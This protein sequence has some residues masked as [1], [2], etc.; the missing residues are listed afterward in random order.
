MGSKE[1]PARLCNLCVGEGRQGQLHPKPGGSPTRRGAGLGRE[2]STDRRK[3]KAAAA[4]GAGEG[5]GAAGRRGQVCRQVEGARSSLAWSRCGQAKVLLVGM[6]QRGQGPLTFPDLVTPHPTSQG[7]PWPFPFALAGLGVSGGSPLESSCLRLRSLSPPAPHPFL[8]LSLC[9][10]CCSRQNAAQFLRNSRQSGRYTYG[11]SGQPGVQTAL[12]WDRGWWGLRNP[13][14]KGGPEGSQER[15]WEG[16]GVQEERVGWMPSGGSSLGP[17]TLVADRPALGRQPPRPPGRV[18]ARALIQGVGR[19]QQALTHT[20]RATQRPVSAHSPSA[21]L[22]GSSRRLR[23][24]R[25]PASPLAPSPAP[26]PPGVPLAWAPWCTPL[27][28]AV[29]PG[30]GTRRDPAALGDTTVRDVRCI[31]LQ[32]WGSVLTRPDRPQAE[33]WVGSF[34][35][36][37]CSAPAGAPQ[38]MRGLSLATSGIPSH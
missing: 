12:D 19:V 13:G 8:Q 32:R 38:G 18:S 29:G 34:Y 25:V 30:Q 6:G 11:D 22:G 9:E 33:A 20:P 21:S 15:E 7:P 2:G 36:Y 28:A 26:G 16:L 3:V 24:G 31:T 37:R 17:N 10:P 14:G 1:H 4:G 35:D 5:R 27:C 23:P